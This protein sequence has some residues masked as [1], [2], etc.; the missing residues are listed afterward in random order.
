MQMLC[1]R[2]EKFVAFTSQG[3]SVNLAPRSTDL[4]MN[5]LYCIFLDVYTKIL[6]PGHS[7]CKRTKQLSAIY[8]VQCG[9]VPSLLKHEHTSRSSIVEYVSKSAEYNKEQKRKSGKLST[10]GDW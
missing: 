6:G 3:T 1:Y 7:I 5:I 2:Q 4:T 10:E 9:K 8:C